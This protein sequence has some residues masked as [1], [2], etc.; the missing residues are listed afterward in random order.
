MDDDV[1]GNIVV[2]PY[3]VNS[4][5]RMRDDWIEKHSFLAWVCMLI[6]MAVTDIFIFIYF[7]EMLLWI[8][9]ICLAWNWIGKS[10]HVF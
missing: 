7:L 9:L 3:E 6:I 2:M 1:I 10:W 4:I 5:L 8:L